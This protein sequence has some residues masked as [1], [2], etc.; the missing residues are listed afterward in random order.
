MPRSRA[1]FD[2]A[3][4]G[5]AAPLALVATGGWARRELA[6]YSDIDFIVLH[7][8]RR[9]LR[10]AARR[11]APVSAVG[12]EARDRPC[13]PRGERNRPARARDLPTA[14]ALLDARH[15]AGDRRLTT[16]LMRATLGALAP[17]GNPNDFIAMLAAEQKARHERF[18]ASLYLLEP[19]LKQGIG[20][21]RDLATALWAAQVRWHPP[22]PGEDP[23]PTEGLIANLVSMGHLTRRQGDVLANA[24]DFMLRIRTLVQLTAKRRFDQLTFEIQ[25]ALG[26]SLYPGAKRARG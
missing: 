3:K 1:R 15:I 16:D 20:A 8:Q 21:L 18:G 11:R 23:E 6:P 12:R 24:R 2:E 22:R 17:G 14:T 9:G 13:D 4:A 26:P 5:I 10:E 19:N 25:E 7:E